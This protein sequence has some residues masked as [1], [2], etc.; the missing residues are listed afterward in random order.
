GPMGTDW[1]VYHRIDGPIVMIGFGSI[2]RGTLPL[3]ERHFAFDRSKLVVIDPSDEA[4][5][6]AEARGVRFIQQAVTRDNYRELLVPLLTAG[7]GQ[8]FCVNL[9]VDTSSLDIMELARE[10]GALYIDTVVEPWLGFYFDPDLKPE[11]RSNYALRETVLA[12]RRNKPGG[13]TAVSCCGANP[14]MVSW[15]VKQALVNLAADLGVTGE[16]PTTREEWARLAM[17]LGVKGI[18]IAQRDTQRAS[19][20]K[21]FDVFVNTWSVEGFVSE[22]LQPAELGWGTFERWMP[23]NA[24]GHDSGCGAG[25]YLLQPGAN[26]RVRSWTPTAMAQYGFLV[27]H[28]E[29]ISIAD[30]LTVRDAAGQA[31]YRPTCHYA[32]HPCNDAV[33]SLHEMFG[34][35]KRQSD[36]RIL[37]ETEIVDGIDELGVLL[38]GHGKNAYWYGSQLSIEE[39][40]RIAPDQ[41]ATG[42][43][44]SSAVLAGMVWALENPNAGIVE[45]DDLDFRRCLEVQTP[46]LGPVVGVYTD[47]TPLAGRPG[48]FPEDIDTSDPWQFRNV[49]VRD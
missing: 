35:G 17:D 7:P 46:Y 19:F 15:F 30:F 34:S 48:L 43:Q 26:T 21:P 33:L 25:I 22:G 47:W 41:N 6:L 40:R 31:V 12:A 18:H 4:R 9:S 24:R 11:A 49:L 36:W 28:N 5:K 32:Y 42:L 13:T 37:D 29:S 39:T 16:E 45:A 8:G 23:D 10:N 20:P 44:V 14:G 1:P 27:T 38:Y 2:G 3:I